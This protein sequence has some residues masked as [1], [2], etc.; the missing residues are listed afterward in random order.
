MFRGSAPAK[1]DDK[2]RLKIP[3]DFRRL[4]EERYGQDLFVTSVVGD[5]ALIYPLMVWEEIEQKLVA[6]PSTDR[7]KV[8]YLERVNY[9]G[10]Q[11]SLDVQG[12]I[13]IPQL[14]RE[15]AGMNGD[16]VVSGQLNHLVIWNHER[17]AKRLEDQPFTD[18]DFHALSLA[19][20]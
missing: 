1:I 15:S 16:V 9:F 18:E 11:V 2:G 7:T 10:Q 4:I 12:R 20:I 13:L 17:F 6:L 8:R 5:S 14:L 19:G 3:T